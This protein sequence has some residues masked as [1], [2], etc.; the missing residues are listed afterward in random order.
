MSLQNS[1][2]MSCEG[3]KWDEVNFR[4]A[5][6]FLDFQGICIFENAKWSTKSSMKQTKNISTFKHQPSYL[7]APNK[8]DLTQMGDT[9]I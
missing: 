2:I 9:P 5:L 1:H 6:P 4:G 8:I 7:L 3:L